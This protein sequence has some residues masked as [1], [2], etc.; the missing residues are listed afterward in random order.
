MEEETQP[1]V[2]YQAVVEIYDEESLNYELDDTSG[3]FADYAD[4]EAARKAM[5]AD[6]L[7]DSRSADEVTAYV[8]TWRIDGKPKREGAGS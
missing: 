5:L 3:M 4:A 6:A 1:F 8:H 2:V 7:A